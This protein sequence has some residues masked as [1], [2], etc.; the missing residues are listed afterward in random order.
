MLLPQ[1][2]NNLTVGRTFSYLNIKSNATKGSIVKAITLGRPV[3]G[4]GISYTFLIVADSKARI[5]WQKNA[6]MVNVRQTTLPLQ[7]L[8]AN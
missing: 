4:S 7:Q 1:T 3:L 5:F 6:D 8:M 2:K